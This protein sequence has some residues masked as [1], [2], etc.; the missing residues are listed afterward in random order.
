[1]GKIGICS[2]ICSDL[3]SSTEKAEDNV[4]CAGRVAPLGRRHEENRGFSVESKNLSGMNS[5]RLTF[6]PSCS[7]Q[8]GSGLQ[9]FGKGEKK[10]L[11]FALISSRILFSNGASVHRVCVAALR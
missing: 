6:L 1:M 7:Q 2:P 9:K 11:L 5:S 8:P 3:R 4:L 10:N